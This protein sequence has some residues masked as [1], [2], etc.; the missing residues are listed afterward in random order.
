MTQTELEKRARRGGGALVAERLKVKHAISPECGHAY[1]ALRWEGSDLLARPYS[2]KVVHTADLL[3][4]ELLFL[5]LPSGKLAHA[6]LAFMSRGV[7][8]IA[9]AR[10]GAAL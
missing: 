8:G 9:L 1:S 5:W 2:F 4:V 3:S 10:K 6:F 7:T